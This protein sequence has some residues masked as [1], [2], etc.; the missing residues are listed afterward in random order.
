MSDGFEVTPAELRAHAGD[1]SSVSSQVSAASNAAGVALSLSPQAFGILCSFFTPPC[2]T[3]STVA[4][5]SMGG[6]QMGATAFATTM[7]LVADDFETT[8]Q[9]VEASMTSLRG[10]L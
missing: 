2:L 8:D 1:V 9:G 7:P 10:R 4:I 3:M 6:I 5:S